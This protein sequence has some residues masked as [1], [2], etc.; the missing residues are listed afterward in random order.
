MVILTV[1]LLLGTS[2]TPLAA[3][4]N[5]LSD[6]QNLDLQ[7]IS[8]SLKSFDKDSLN[9]DLPR[10][11]GKSLNLESVPKEEVKVADQCSKTPDPKKIISKVNDVIEKNVAPEDLLGSLLIYKTIDC[12]H[13]TPQ[14]DVT[15]NLYKGETL[16]ATGKTDSQG[17][18]LLKGIKYGHYHLKEEIPEGYVSGIKNFWPVIVFAKGITPVHVVNRLAPEGT[19][20]IEL[21]KK[22]DKGT[23][24][25]EISFELYQNGKLLKT[26]AT[27]VEGI[28]TF[29]NLTPGDYQL[30]EIVPTGYK[31]SLV[32]MTTVKVKANETTSISVVN[33]K[34]EEIDDEDPPLGPI[35][36]ENPNNPKDPDNATIEIPDEKT[37]TGKAKLPKTGSL[38]SVWYYG[39]GFSLLL[40]GLTL[41]RKA[42]K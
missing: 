31:S 22:D 27:N 29:T 10:V 28:T 7:T 2:L 37:P 25:K 17:K 12:P 14:A 5:D 8:K 40:A 23:P 42:K 30:K 6:L 3:S 36:P 19:G 4:F 33:T 18:L 15:F 34:I 1:A 32:D 11:E 24:Q 13:G 16:V 21:S 38:S 9:L 20:I 35:D 39:S 26:Q 41:K